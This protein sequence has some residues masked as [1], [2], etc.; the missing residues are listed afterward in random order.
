MDRFADMGH[1]FR[2]LSFWGQRRNVI[3]PANNI[4]PIEDTGANV[5]SMTAYAPL[6]RYDSSEILFMPVYKTE[7]L[8]RKAF[9]LL[10]GDCVGLFHA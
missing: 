3:T 2:Y 10:F 4:V 1:T 5:S 9:E 8:D 6:R 7:I